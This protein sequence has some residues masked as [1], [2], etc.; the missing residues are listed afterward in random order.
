MRNLGLTSQERALNYAA[1]NAFQV[2]KVFQR[3]IE[4]ETQLDAIEVGTSPVCRPGAD[5]RDVKLTFFNPT[6]RLEQ[7]RKVFRFTVDV[8]DVVPVTVGTV[9]Q[10]HVY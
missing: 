5:C 3:A 8:T 9:R 6:R 1:T 10:W 4:D 2:Q 7:A